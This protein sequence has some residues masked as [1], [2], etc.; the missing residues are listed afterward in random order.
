MVYVGSDSDP[1]YLFR[2]MLLVHE[3]MATQR[4]EVVV[5]GGV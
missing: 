4:A 5:C 2:S 3:L 1:T